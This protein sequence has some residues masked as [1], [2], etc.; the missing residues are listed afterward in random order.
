MDKF[1]AKKYYSRPEIQKAI[2]E[3]AK[4]RE[5]GLR[6]DGYF[7]KRPGVLEYLSDVKNAVK[8]DIFSFH[9]SEE[10]WENPLLLG[11][12]KLSD[13]ERSKNRV[14]WDLIL[15]LDGIDIKH[16]K[17]VAKIIIEFLQGL[18]I[19]NIS[20]KFSGNKGFHIGIPF[21]AFSKEIIGIGETRLLF[22]EAARRMGSYLIHELGP[23]F[24][25]AILEEEGSIEKIS[26][27]YN[28]EM[29]KILTKDEKSNYFNYL[30]LI[31]ID[32]I[33]ISSRHLFRMPY[34]LNEKSGFVSIPIRNDLIMDF[35]K[36]IAKPHKVDPDK[37]KDFEFLKYDESHGKDADILLI[38]AYED[39][40]TEVISSLISSKKKSE[41]SF[42]IKEKIDIKDFPKTIQFA[43]NHDFTD[44]KKR[45]IFLLLTFLTSVNWD[46]KNIEELLY[47]WNDRQSEKLKKNYI[48]AQISWFKAQGKKISPPNF[49]NANYYESIGIEKKVIEEDKKRFKDREVKNPLHYVIL[50]S[51]KG[52]KK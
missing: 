30:E 4:N 49:D 7:G 39:D 13:E 40:Y 23:K 26:K 8:E 47:S 42:E 32:T 50:L 28:I 5:I 12:D 24:S 37:K 22:P 17:I 19:K 14:G 2:L 51:Q 52:K 21:E 45:A 6:Y 33:L 3:F 43:L 29:D 48:T 27:K 25:N 16:S 20:T 35:E 11:N 10:R 1:L 15:D 41:V 31:E 44:G 18:G 46:I 38:K 34:S 9:M 36:F